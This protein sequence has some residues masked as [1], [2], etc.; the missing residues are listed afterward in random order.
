[1]LLALIATKAQNI[2]LHYDYGK[3]RGYLTSTVEMYKT[4]KWGATFFFIDMN[5]S[6]A[7]NVDGVS[8]AYWE[9]SRTIKLGKNSPLS[10]QVEYNGGM[11]K[12]YADE[13]LGAFTIN[14]AYLAGLDYSWN[15][16]DFSK[17]F[18]IKTLYKN[19]RDKNNVSFQITGV[20][21]YNTSNKKITFKGFAD[22][23]KE[24]QEWDTDGDSETDIT[25]KYIFLS[26]SQLWYN[27]TKN[28]SFGGEVEISNNFIANNFKIMPTV[29][30]KW[31]F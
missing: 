12:F 14:D 10:A 21:H 26:E 15:T 28:I 4:D 9:I 8:L 29:A 31:T 22:F 5:Y 16:D 20:W 19:I 23:W 18:S 6:V 7:E 2:Q 24:N 27:I 3:D 11:G 30:L 17:G 25:S 1:M 13:S